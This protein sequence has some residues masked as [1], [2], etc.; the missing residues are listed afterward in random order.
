[1]HTTPTYH[2]IIQKG[3]DKLLSKGVIEPS[4]DGA[5]FY[6]NI[7]LFLSIL[8]ASVLF[9]ILSVLITLCTYLLTRCLLS[10]NYG[11]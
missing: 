9:P 10:N 2:S 5:D 6:S 7:L 3:V 4:S 1:M 11:Y 8:V